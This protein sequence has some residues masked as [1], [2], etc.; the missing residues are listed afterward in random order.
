MSIR[1][2]NK[3]GS[4]AVVTKIKIQHWTAVKYGSTNGKAEL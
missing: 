4:S 2:R 1:Q 3:N